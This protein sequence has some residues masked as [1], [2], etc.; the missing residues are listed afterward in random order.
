VT[1]RGRTSSE[2]FA[3]AYLI[4]AAPRLLVALVLCRDRLAEWV[5]SGSLDEEDHAA[6]RIASKEI[7]KAMVASLNGTDTTEG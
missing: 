3:N 6:V 2:T 7:A 1:H 5:N 4:A